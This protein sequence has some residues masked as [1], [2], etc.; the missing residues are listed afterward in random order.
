MARDQSP[1]IN[2]FVK[3]KNLTFEVNLMVSR[4][5]KVAEI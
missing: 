5:E 1:N 4:Q 2:I 3:K